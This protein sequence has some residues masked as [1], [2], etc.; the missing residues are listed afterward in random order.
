[1]NIFLKL[2]LTGLALI[3]IF[4]GGVDFFTTT[5]PGVALLVSTWGIKTKV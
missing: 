5:I 1:M 4:A 3:L 2:F